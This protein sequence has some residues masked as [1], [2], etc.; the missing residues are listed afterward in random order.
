MSL[1]WSQKVNNT[2]SEHYMHISSLVAKYPLI[3]EMSCG[4]KRP[5]A[6]CYH[7]YF[8]VCMTPLWCHFEEDSTKILCTAISQWGF[9]WMQIKWSLQWINVHSI[10]TTIEITFCESASRCFNWDYLEALASTNFQVCR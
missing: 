7:L 8:S 6:I 4:K 2:F 1:M 10:N 5:I 3:E 9:Q